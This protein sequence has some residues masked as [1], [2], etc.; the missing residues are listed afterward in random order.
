MA[1]LQKHKAYKYKEKVHFKY[2][3]NIPEDLV[4]KLCWEEGEDLR[5]NVHD[6][7]LI[8]DLDSGEKKR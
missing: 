8:I 1:K 6:N 7:K 2:L 4:E 3:I 5:L